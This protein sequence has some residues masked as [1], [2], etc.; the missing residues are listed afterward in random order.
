MKIMA[1]DDPTSVYPIG[2]TGLDDDEESSSEEPVA[3]V[4]P[5]EPEVQAP[6]PRPVAEHGGG[7]SPLIALGVLG[8]GMVAAALLL[9]L[10]TA[11]LLVLN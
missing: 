10:V 5:I 3:K 7:F 11:V 6:T 9:G 1:P 2:Q 8:L 4:P